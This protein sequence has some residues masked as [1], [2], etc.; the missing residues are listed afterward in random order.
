[1]RDLLRSSVLAS[2]LAPSGSK[3][4]ENA[5]LIF[6]GRVTESI[7]VTGALH[8]PQLFWTARR[9]VNPLR[10]AAR[11]PVIISAAD[12]QNGEWPLSYRFLRRHVVGIE[13]AEFL[14]PMH[15]NDHS[16]QKEG[17]AQ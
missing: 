12:Q 6:S 15:C 5:S 13:P 10:V 3:E 1:M 17:L 4:L 7:S 2:A 16:R 9:S 11:N 8:D 14:N